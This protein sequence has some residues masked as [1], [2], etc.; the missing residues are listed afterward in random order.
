MIQIN[1]KNRD[2]LKIINFYGYSL[3]N[4]KKLSIK[5]Y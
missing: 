5:I 3:I 4:N 2:E 1:L